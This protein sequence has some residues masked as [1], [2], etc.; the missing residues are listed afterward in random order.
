MLQLFVSLF[1]VYFLLA[2]TTAISKD[3][4]QTSI[5]IDTIVIKGSNM[6]PQA[7]L[8][9]LIQR[10]TRNIVYK[11]DSSIVNDTRITL[12]P[13]KN[14]RVDLGI[15]EESACQAIKSPRDTIQG[16]IIENKGWLI[17]SIEKQ[18]VVCKTTGGQTFV[19]SFN[20]RK[21][22]ISLATLIPLLLI[23]ILTPLIGFYNEKKYPGVRAVL[24]KFRAPILI[25]SRLSLFYCFCVELRMLSDIREQIILFEHLLVSGFMLA[26]IQFYFDTHFTRLNLLSWT[27]F[28]L[29]CLI[30]FLT[31]FK[32]FL[33]YGVMV[34]FIIAV[35]NFIPIIIGEVNKESLGAW[36]EEKVPS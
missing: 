16:E 30:G 21:G 13:I 4:Y 24:E 18:M 28:Q 26:A 17:K 15:S 34:V 32:A 3:C 7:D 8:D 12:I 10:T 22:S 29:C 14:L 31:E 35:I 33:F 23:F 27:V 1:M 9:F 5:V 36:K 6:N 25:I 2:P 20:K 11:A 19:Y